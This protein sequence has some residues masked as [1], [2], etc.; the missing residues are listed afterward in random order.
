MRRR[1]KSQ[2]DKDGNGADQGFCDHWH[3]PEE[4]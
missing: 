4:Y 2:T 3:S 1:S